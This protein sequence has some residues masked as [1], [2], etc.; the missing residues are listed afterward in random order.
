MPIRPFSLASVAR[1]MSDAVTVPSRTRRDSTDAR[2]TDTGSLV[3]PWFQFALPPE[4]SLAW[5]LPWPKFLF[6]LTRGLAGLR[7][8]SKLSFSLSAQC[9]VLPGNMVGKWLQSLR[10]QVGTCFGLSSR[11]PSVR[12]RRSENPALWLCCAPAQRHSSPYVLL[13]S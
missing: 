3:T 7:R 1:L 5:G 2:F 13:P 6:P 10:W 9:I 4:L 11:P 12:A 8:S